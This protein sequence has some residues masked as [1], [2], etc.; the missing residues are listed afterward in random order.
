MPFEQQSPCS[1]SLFCAAR[2]KLVHSNDFQI[3]TH[4]GISRMCEVFLPLLLHI[5]LDLGVCIAP[6]SQRHPLV[7][8]PK[9]REPRHPWLQTAVFIEEVWSNSAPRWPF[10]FSHV[11]LRQEVGR[12]KLYS[13]PDGFCGMRPGD[14]AVD[15]G[16]FQAWT[17]PPWLKPEVQS[18]DGG[19]KIHADPQ[20]I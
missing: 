19:L 13:S 3:V 14:L 16:R 2:G 11:A 6:L 10:L 8:P 15:P 1:S 20:E 12:R 4:Q 17:L 18:P 5:S 9:Q 7:E